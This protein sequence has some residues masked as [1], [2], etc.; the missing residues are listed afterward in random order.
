MLYVARMMKLKWR[1]IVCK[2]LARIG[3]ALFHV[4]LAAAAPCPQAPGETV[5]VSEVTDRLELQLADGRRI[6]L[7]GLE[8]PAPGE[9]RAAALQNDL[10]Q[11]LRGREVLVRPLAP[12]PDR[13][14]R[15]P[16]QV[17]GPLPAASEPTTALPHVN[18]ALAAAG[19]LRVEPGAEANDCLAL[20]YL[21]EAQARGVKFGIWADPAFAPV[22]ADDT[23]ALAA[24]SGQFTLVEG[25]AR[26]VGQGR[27]RFY[28]DFGKGRGDFS[29]T[30]QKRLAKRFAQ[31][32]RP[33]ESL[34]GQLLR[35]RG[36]IDTRYGPQIDISG[37]E[38]IEFIGGSVDKPL[39]KPVDK[40]A[41]R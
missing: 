29:V 2:P 4:C 30:V 14:G 9:A 20:L 36:V 18:E 21:A 41:G 22:D 37:P 15:L 23:D 13:W 35:V 12:K 28:L 8:R 6:R 7:A 32:G 17:F 5:T 34:A 26:R 27:S 16:A 40:E 19:L 25:R 31:A 11:W 3:A 38:E 1:K 33:L 39:T 24:R 10:S